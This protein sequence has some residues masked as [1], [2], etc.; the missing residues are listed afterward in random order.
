MKNCSPW[1]S[2]KAIKREVRKLKYVD[3]GAVK[4]VFLSEWKENKVALSQLT[5]VPPTP[6][7][8]SPAP[9]FH[10]SAHAVP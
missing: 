10:A 7:P 9:R 8:L 4:M 6:P 1:L 3:E 5:V 2:C